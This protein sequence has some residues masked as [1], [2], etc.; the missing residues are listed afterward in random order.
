[1][2]ERFFKG[3]FAFSLR[4]FM[5]W[6]PLRAKA[7]EVPEQSYYRIVD[8]SELGDII[9]YFPTNLAHYFSRSG[10]GFISTYSSTISTFGM[11]ENGS[12]QYDIRFG[13]DDIPHY[14][15]GSSS[16]NYADLHILSI[17]ETNLTFLNDT[18]FTVFSQ[19]TTVSMIFLFIAG[20]IL[21]TLLKRR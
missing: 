10:N 21:V 6:S 4:I 12:T 19:D 1:M 9:I 13:F 15:T 3:F 2:Y 11:P 18:D 8:T 5:L 17:I 16:Y 14:S 7:F 20:A